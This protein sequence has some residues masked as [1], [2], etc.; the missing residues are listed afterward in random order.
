MIDDF[1][2]PTELE[3]INA[4]K[5]DGIDV[6]WLS[7][8]CPVQSEGVIDYHPYYFKAR[9]DNWFIQI[10]SKPSPYT[11]DVFTDENCWEYGELYGEV[12]DAGYMPFIEA[13]GFIEVAA[14]RWRTTKG[15][16]PA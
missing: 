7:G 14:N 6:Q 9:G 5:D 15:L 3:K 10:G 11:A 1:Y 8:L 12:P 4:L 2:S 13:L 16:I